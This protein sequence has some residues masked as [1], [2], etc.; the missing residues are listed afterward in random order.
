MTRSSSQDTTE[1]AATA[2][3]SMRYRA[4]AVDR[5]RAAC[6]VLAEC[7]EGTL[8]LEALAEAVARRETDVSE[9][10]DGERQVAITLHHLHLPLLA[11]AGVLEYDAARKRVRPDPDALAQ[12]VD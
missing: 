12:D 6:D 4:V 3:R 11:S 1:Q 8:S 5:R 2:G 7:D 9:A 10:G